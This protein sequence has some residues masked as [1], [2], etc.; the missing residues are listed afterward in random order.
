MAKISDSDTE[1]QY[2]HYFEPLV[3]VYLF[4]F[5]NEIISLSVFTVN[6]DLLSKCRFL[7]LS[8]ISLF[9]FLDVTM[10]STFVEYQRM[11]KSKML[12][13]TRMTKAADC[14]DR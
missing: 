3:H 1:K 4:L 9:V 12:Q 13:K 7:K 8:L 14:Y 2:M 10:F 11:K 5:L 6:L